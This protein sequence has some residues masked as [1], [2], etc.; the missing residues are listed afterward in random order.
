GEPITF[1]LLVDPADGTAHLHFGVIVED[2]FGTKLFT[3][4]SYLSDS[5]LPPLLGPSRVISRLDQ[6]D[7]AP[8]RYA[9][10][11]IAGPIGKVN[12]EVIDQAAWFDVVE[13]DFYGNG[14]LPEAQRG[15]FLKRSRWEV[16]G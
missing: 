10:S 15:R 1:E 13:A 2:A 14:R 6:L 4:G 11:L 16:V 5:V 3:V 7:L 12:T 9:L 8:G